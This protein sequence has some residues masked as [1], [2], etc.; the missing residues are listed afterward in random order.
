MNAGYRLKDQTERANA[1]SGSGLARRRTS[2]L[3][4]ALA[5]AALTALVFWPV[6]GQWIG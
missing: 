5:L 1:M 3:V 2:R 6:A 4:V